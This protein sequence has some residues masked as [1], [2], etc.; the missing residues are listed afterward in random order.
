[1]Q[2]IY[3]DSYGKLLMAIGS[4]CVQINGILNFFIYMQRMRGF[5]DV[6]FKMLHMD[7]LTGQ[8]V[9]VQVISL[10]AHTKNSLQPA[11]KHTEM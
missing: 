2:N 6:I 8:A 3:S 7:K 4:C 10:N 9:A 1:L 11:P 5:R